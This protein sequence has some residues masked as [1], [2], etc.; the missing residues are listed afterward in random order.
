MKRHSF[1][2]IWFG[3]LLSLLGSSLTSFG[4]SLWIFEH[5][6]STK[7]LATVVFCNFFP[8]IYLSLFA[9]N[10]V[11]GVNRRALLI[12]TNVGVGITSFTIY[13]LFLT[14]HL[15]LSWIY[16]VLLI[17]GSFESFQSLAL[18]TTVSAFVKKESYH[19]YN[20]LISMI[21]SLPLALGPIL[22]GALLEIIGF[23]GILLIDIITFF[24][25]ALI[26]IF[27][28]FPI[29]QPELRS[30]ISTK[31]SILFGI[32]TIFS[33]TILLRLQ[34]FFTGFNF[35]NG[36]LAGLI[37]AFILVKSGGD[38]NALALI[39]SINAVGGFLGG[40][41]VGFL[42]IRNYALHFILIGTFFCGLLGRVFFGLS[43]SV[44]TWCTFLLLRN[45][46]VPIINVA[47][48][49]LWQCEVPSE[50]QGRV[51]G[52]RR[53]L[54]QGLYPLSVFLGGM[55]SESL[56]SDECVAKL[57]PARIIS[58]GF[59]ISIF[60]VTMGLFEMLI[61]LYGMRWLWVK[62][63]PLLRRRHPVE[64]PVT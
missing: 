40:A 38:K 5:T 54:A 43:D 58:P 30:K 17:A 34:S 59:G 29:E 64:Y 48:Q 25:A 49:T 47:N 10:I 61:S 39:L 13:G 12:V 56:F 6:G 4:L 11:D 52:A 20:G 45:L 60:F 8:K 44:A 51:F 22:A 31:V 21:E 33:N 62:D 28:S 23:S 14:N 7:A 35:F 32:K 1:F 19:R 16:F 3:Q 57:F 37:S 36:L 15:T 27:V 24:V 18:Q 50:E 42:P 63:M 55:L 2:F 41:V 46:L 26:L 53:L 9:G